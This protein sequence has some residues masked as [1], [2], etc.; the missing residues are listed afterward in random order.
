MT[1]TSIDGLDTAL[2]E[3]QG[4]GLKM[5]PTVKNYLSK[6][7]GELS[8]RLRLISQRIPIT[9]KEIAK[10]AHDL[11]ILHLEA[12]NEL[13]G[14][15][16]IDL[17]CVHGQTVYHA[18]PLSLQ[19]INPTPIAIGLNVPVVTDLRAADLAMGGQG[20]PITPIADFT[21]YRSSN[22]RRG[23]VN[24]GGFCNMT[25]LPKTPANAEKT[26]KSAISRIIGRDVCACNQ[27]LD[28]I[29]R[30]LFK[31][32]MDVD[33]D[34][35]RAGEVKSEPFDAMMQHLKNQAASKRSLGTGDEIFIGWIDK[36]R[37]NF[38]P[39]DLARSA[40]AAIAAAIALNCEATDRI[41]L[42]GGGSKNKTLVEEITGR[43]NIP[44]EFSCEHGIP[45]THREA[46]AMAA[47]GALCQDRVPITLPQVTGATTSS[48][49]GIWALP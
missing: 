26:F 22:E 48:I 2:V 12:L 18:P 10:T 29:A 16:K 44:V 8:S 17:V 25:L 43:S 7:L 35:S 14:N 13:I 36:Y 32:P 38:G 9:A 11:A 49:S 1:G 34:K 20:A 45:S 15:N 40:C 19:M 30:K 3:I 23:I 6:P 24:L 39:E 37:E 31:I 42:A 5:K 46:A 28:N 4:A 47:L 41:I 33:G 27:I 21:L